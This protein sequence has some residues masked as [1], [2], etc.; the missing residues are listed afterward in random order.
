M[1]VFVG[2]R[3]DSIKINCKKESCTKHLGKAGC[4]HRSTS[5]LL[6][7]LHYLCFLLQHFGFSSL[8]VQ[9]FLEQVNDSNIEKDIVVHLRERLFKSIVQEH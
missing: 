8:Q 1:K 6:K 5:Y 9:L 3:V 2:L 4:D 7:I